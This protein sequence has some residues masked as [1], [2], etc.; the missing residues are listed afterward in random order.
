M[1]AIRLHWYGGPE[2][3]ILE[4]VPIP[5]PAPGE[6]LLRVNGAGVGPWDAL[7][8]EGQSKLPETLPLTPGSDIAGIVERFGDPVSDFHAG[9][10]V[11]GVTN[12][13]FVGGY[14]EFAFASSASVASKPRTLDFAAAA[15]VPVVAVTARQMLFDRAAVKRG[16]SVLV[17]G[18]AGS[19]GAYVVQMAHRAGANV[20]AVAGAADASYVR[21]LGADAA[22]DFHSQRFEDAIDPVDVVIDLVGGD[23]QERS[24]AVLKPGGILVSSV[25]QPSEDR[26]AHFG[27]RVAFFVVSV[28]RETLEQIGAQIDAGELRTNVGV[29]LP[30]A[31]AKTAHQMLAGVVSHPRG[32]IVLDTNVAQR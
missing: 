21:D 26:A 28:E 29:V 13:A 23:V 15:S 14:A 9:D 2:E 17:Q 8:R 4:D 22:I 30:L 1:K 31:D 27:V 19:V 12:A 6:L 11:Y 24:F 3:L 25:S 18:A 7:V 16:Q 10:A 32:K 20:T 5:E